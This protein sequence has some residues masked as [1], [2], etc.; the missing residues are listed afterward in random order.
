MAL[1]VSPK[2]EV[3][4]IPRPHP[5]QLSTFFVFYF[6]VSWKEL[7]SANMPEYYFPSQGL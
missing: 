4:Q 5:K 2:Q 7:D 6:C 1:E 3:S